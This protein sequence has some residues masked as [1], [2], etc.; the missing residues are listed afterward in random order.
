MSDFI[1]NIQELRLSIAEFQNKPEYWK[2]ILASKP[3]Y[4]VHTILDGK[5]S[6]SLSKFIV[7][8]NVTS[9]DYL[10]RL[11]YSTGGKRA[12]ERIA[13]V[14]GTDWIDYEDISLELKRHFDDWIHHLL[15]K[16][17]M[18][19][20]HFIT[21]D[22]FN[23]SETPFK[24]SISSF[25][26]EKK[27]EKQREIGE[28]GEA[29]ALNFEINRLRKLGVSKPHKKVEQISKI[30]ASAGF[31]ILSKAATSIR[32]IEVKSSTRSSTEFYLSENER[33]TLKKLEN[34]AYIY[35]VR[36]TDLENKEGAVEKV[37]QNPIDVIEEDGTMVPIS[38]KVEL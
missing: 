13:E 26:L 20:A 16:Y 8:R 3:Q 25:E 37:I 5:S 34:E 38:Y 36:I 15:P 28:I 27:L 17:N 7:F 1:E 22:S 10:K 29:I 35:F 12:R 31:D 30:N 24:K 32:Y 19:N 6:F 2:L 9:E 23:S 4:F 11:R 33:E 21:I 14:L 18:L